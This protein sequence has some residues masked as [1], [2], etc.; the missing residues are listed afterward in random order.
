MVTNLETCRLDCFA[1]G[2]LTLPSTSRIRRRSLCRFLKLLV[3]CSQIWKEKFHGE[4]GGYVDWPWISPNKTWVY[5]VISNDL[6]LKY[7]VGVFPSPATCRSMISMVSKLSNV[8]CLRKKMQ[9]TQ[10]VKS[11]KRNF[12]GKKNE[13]QNSQKVDKS[14]WNEN[15]TCCF[16]THSTLFIGS[17]LLHKFCDT[18]WYHLV[19]L[20]KGK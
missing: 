15:K 2:L 14:S 3:P 13:V 18:S 8:H 19:F 10:I 17:C 4:C 7:P 20:L 11:C 6:Q 1:P 12:E 16:S 5:L 9:N